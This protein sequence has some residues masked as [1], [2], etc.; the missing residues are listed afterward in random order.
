ME[1]E[2]V[3]AYTERTGRVLIRPASQSLKHRPLGHLVDAY[4]TTEC[5]LY[6]TKTCKGMLEES[7]LVP[8]TARD[9]ARCTQIET[10]KTRGW[11]ERQRLALRKG[12]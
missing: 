5:G 6:H 2:T 4:G 12:G 11:E 8:S 7:T 1:N 9:C 3:A 10:R